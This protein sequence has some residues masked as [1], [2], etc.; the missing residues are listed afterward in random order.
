MYEIFSSVVSSD[1]N[2]SI[3]SFAVEVKDGVFVFEVEL[4]ALDDD[5]LCVDEEH[6]CQR[7]EEDS[8][9]DE[10]LV[11]LA[12]VYDSDYDCYRTL[13]VVDE[14]EGEG[15]VEDTEVVR[16]FVYQDSG[17]GYVEEL[18]RTADDAIYHLFM[19]AFVGVEEGHMEKEIFEDESE[20]EEENK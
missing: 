1:L 11:D 20:K 13:D 16:E 12:D 15:V 17:R 18:A 9:R 6:N 8:G 10:V 14:G 4:L 2:E 5:W 19:D 3:D 7:Q